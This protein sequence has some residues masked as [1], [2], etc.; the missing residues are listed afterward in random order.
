MKKVINFAYP[1]TTMIK[2]K[3]NKEYFKK[4][5][6]FYKKNYYFRV[7]Y[8]FL[9]NIYICYF[10]YIIFKIKFQHF[11]YKKLYYINCNI[12]INYILEFYLKAI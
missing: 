10:I 4:N 2:I 11:Q 12:N 3:D 6:T 7:I 9:F 5:K 8:N 1:N